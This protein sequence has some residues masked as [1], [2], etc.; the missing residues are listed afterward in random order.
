MTD[1][2]IELRFYKA[3]GRSTP[4]LKIRWGDLAELY[5]TSGCSNEQIG[6]LD[7]PGTGVALVCDARIKL[8]QF[9][10]IEGVNKKGEKRSA[11]SWATWR[12]A[13]D[14]AAASIQLL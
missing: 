9:V 5:R 2:D 4:D 8:E 11:T 6:S 12:L 14:V 3:H 7:G 10:L 1:P 13:D